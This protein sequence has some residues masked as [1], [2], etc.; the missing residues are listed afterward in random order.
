MSNID[1]STRFRFLSDL[2]ASDAPAA[3]LLAEYP[4]SNSDD[5]AFQNKSRFII[6]DPFP[7]PRRELL[8]V[9]GPHH[10]MCCWGSDLPVCS[11]LA[12]P[13]QLLDHWRRIFGDAGVPRWQAVDEVT[14][15]IPLFPHQSLR[16]DQQVVDPETN[17]RLHS[18]EV[19]AEI[20]CPQADVLDSIE[21]PCIVKL[22]HGYAGLGNFLLK[23]A[24]DEAALQK[25]LDQHWPD[26]VLVVNSIIE[27]INGDFGV[28]FYLRK[29]GSVVW[30]GFTEQR[31]DE[32]LRWC[33]G[34]FSAKQQS[35]L[36]GGFSSIIEPAAKH[37]HSH[38]YFGVVGIDILRDTSGRMFLVDVNP[39][40]T[41]ISPFLMASRIFLADEGLTEGIYR[42]SCRFRGTMEQLFDAAESVSDGRV[43]V[44][45]AF[46]DHDSAAATETA[47][48]LSASS[49]S[50]KRNGAI[51]DA[52]LR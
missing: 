28:Q 34:L 26:A 23:S 51:L 10:L 2:Y 13:P 6:H 39:R 42:A 24:E 46:E 15:Y 14:P 19:I 33:G 49:S 43:L 30:L 3:A 27:N 40:L 52:I 37:L 48:H 22:S 11:E 9:L 18:K 31:F 35:E 7:P 17:Y 36:L 47:C 21:F 41:G 16:P 4:S 38:G 1:T 45:S 25:Q 44:L 50:Q 5:T 8:K 12:P 32:N 29:D 20:D